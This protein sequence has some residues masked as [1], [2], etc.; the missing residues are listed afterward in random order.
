MCVFGPRSRRTLLALLLLLG[1]SLL[2]SAYAQSVSSGIIQ[3]VVSDPAGAI[4]SGATITLTDTATNASREETSN[5]TGRYIFANVTPGVYNLTVNKQGFRATKFVKQEVTVGTTVNL[6][7]KLEIGSSVETIEV[8]AGGVTLDTSSA[9]VGNTLTGLPLDNLP[10]LGRDVSTFVTLQPGVGIDGSVAGANQD[11]NTFMLD[12]GNNSSDMDGTQNTY[13]PSFAGDPSGGLVGQVTGTAVGGAPGGGG[14]TGVMPTPAD[15]IEEF[16]VGTNNQSA[17]F[18]ASAGAQVQLVTKRGTNNW[19]GTAYEYYLD[20]AWGANGFNNDVSGSAK[21][22]YHY[23]RFG[24]SIG[25][26][27]IPKDFLGGKWFLFANYEGFRWNDSTTITRAVPSEALEQGILQFGGVAYN[28]NPGPVTYTGP[29]TAAL[30]TG[31]VVAP[32]TCPAG[33]CDPRG[34]GISPVMQSLWTQYMPASNIS[35]CGGITRCDG[36]NILS[37]RGNMLI[38]W[39]DNFGVLRLDH[40]FS[41]RWHMYGTYRYY[42]MA[43]ATGNQIDIGGFFPGDTKGIPASVSARPQ[44]P[45]YITGGLTTNISTSLTNDFHYSYLRNFW[46]RSSKAQPP[47][48]DGLGGALEPL[49]E[50]S[51][52]VLAP[53]NLDTQD[54]RTR[55]WDGQDNMF[56]DDLSWAK[57]KHFFQFGGTYQRNWNYHERTDNGGGINYNNVYWTGVSVG[58]GVNGMDM[59]GYIPDAVTALG[60]SSLNNYQRD[61]SMVLGAIGVSQVANTRTGADLNLNPT[62]TPAFDKVTIPFY[63]LYVGDTWRMTPTFTLSYGLGW[64]LEMPPTEAQGKQIVLVDANDKPVYIEQ[65]LKD[66]EQAALAGQVYNPEIGFSLIHN[67]AGNP[68]YPYN[69]FYK[70]FSPRV[71]VA[72]APRADDGL[73]GAIFGNNKTVVRSGYSILYGRLNGVGLVLIPLLG[74]GLIQAVQCVDPLVN[75]SCA[76]SG[77]ANP[78]TAFRIGP[79][80]L[81]APLPAASQTLPQPT[82]PGFNAVAAGAGTGIDPNFRP[83]K[84]QQFDLTIQ[85]QI[86]SRFTMEAG[87]I[88]RLLTNEFMP[89]QINSVPY[90]MTLGGQ[91]FDK[92]YGQMVFQY[93][94]GNAGLAGGNCA[95]NLAAVTPE[96]F[97]EHALN[98]AYC[99]GYASCTQAVAAN[100]GNNGTGNIGLANVWSLWSDLDN[101]AFNFP[102]SMLNTPIAGSA[103][104]ANGQLSS[105][106]VQNTSLGS[107]NYNGMFVSLKMAQFHGVTLQSN[108]TYS[109]ALGTGSQVQ[110]TSQYTNSDPFDLDRNY[111]LQPW[112][113]K[114]LFNTWLVFQPPYFEHQ[115]GFLGHVLGG[116]TLAPIVDLGSGLPL[117]VYT[118]N[119]TNSAYYGGQSFGG[120]D[121]ANTG[122]YENA[123]N[124]CG[125]ASGGSSRHNNPV[126]SSQYPDIGSAGYGPSLYGNPQ[127]IYNCFRNPILGIDDGHNGGSGNLRGQPFW[128]VDFNI[129]KNIAFS[130]RFSLELGAVFTNIFN[131]T[132]L[133]DPYNVL[134]D[135]ADFG[136]LEGQA[137]SPRHIE[138]SGRI[139]F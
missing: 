79:D 97:F 69:P 82:F 102:R 46:A 34:L 66:R 25:G 50:S 9:T 73:L 100:E 112:D 95:G 108:F 118:S 44:L 136:A 26:P 83:S 38:P 11:Q 86:N 12:G 22:S 63:N 123:I 67:V 87:Y 3:G 94:G 74:D 42:K 58:G 41:S 65:Y 119:A 62:G 30:T 110:A 122:S 24:G 43:R 51:T 101:G 125:G 49:G 135:T 137:N 52:N 109:K 132:Q 61:Y 4:V 71:A 120:S 88:G 124:I 113:R 18:N 138:V 130:E 59:S 105:D 5:D 103:F 20:N 2:P 33:A 32:A 10:G 127:A 91:R 1:V 104:G 98:P 72:W 57:G 14:P 19:H 39:Q 133:L 96:P 92:A 36:A 139:R 15:T 7:V 64:S 31:Q 70:G 40:D 106:F 114:F 47:Q 107:G 54:V 80:G 6:D 78:N 75:G 55:F 93:C 126:T 56:R 13:T 129:K 68:K 131:H 29:N 128:N 85:R 117:G 45:Y 28:L 27:I 116:W 111:G 121:G 60:G 8:H 35:T 23:N 115:H 17:D 81:V 84:S 37:F 16:K 99:A 90:M 76:G 21:P 48:L 53:Y 89:L 77:G 134:T